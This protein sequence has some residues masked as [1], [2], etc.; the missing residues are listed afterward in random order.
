[1]PHWAVEQG[2]G[3]VVSSMLDSTIFPHVE[4]V[5]SPFSF[6]DCSPT[7][8]SVARLEGRLPEGGSTKV[9]PALQAVGDSMAV[10]DSTKSEVE[11]VGV[12]GPRGTESPGTGFL[13]IWRDLVAGASRL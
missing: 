12:D 13:L 7:R 9:D 2:G 11:E 1:M 3:I 10:G 8:S 6:A 4:L 5:S